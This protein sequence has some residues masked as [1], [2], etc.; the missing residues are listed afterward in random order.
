MTKGIINYLMTT[1]IFVRKILRIQLHNNL[2]AILFIPTGMHLACGLNDGQLL[3]LDPLTLALLTKTPFKDTSH[4]IINI[5]YSCDS[6]MLAFA[7]S[8]FIS[9]IS[10]TTFLHLIEGSKVEMSLYYQTTVFSAPVIQE[11]P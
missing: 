2:Y 7:V 9:C 8:F 10:S 5:C 4:A 6:M 1:V 11:K 3:F